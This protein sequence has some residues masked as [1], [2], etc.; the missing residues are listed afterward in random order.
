M[1]HLRCTIIRFWLLPLCVAA[2]AA[3]DHGRPPVSA[4]TTI[5]IVRHAEKS[6][7][8]GDVPISDEGKARAKLLAAMLEPAGVSAIFCSELTFNQETAQPIADQ[9]KLAPI[10][11]PVRD[12]ARLVEELRK[13]APGSVTLLVGHSSSIPEIIEKLGGVRPTSIDPQTY[14]RLFI[15]TRWEQ[16][17]VSV[18]EMRYGM[19]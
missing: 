12:S 4:P 15:V 11:I 1:L 6:A 18:I 16:A 3:A 5:V 7:V 2:A 19:P 13:R 10:V 8:S 9:L 14:D 17:P